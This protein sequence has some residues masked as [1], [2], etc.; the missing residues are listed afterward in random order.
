[1]KY[2]FTYDV[3]TLPNCCGVF[4]VG[5][6]EL[7]TVYEDTIKRYKNSYE[8]YVDDEKT[9]YQ[10]AFVRLLAGD[11]DRPIQFWFVRYKD[12]DTEEF[13]DEYH[14]DT[15]RRMVQDHKGVIHLGTYINPNTGNEID[16]YLINSG[17]TKA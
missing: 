14:H 9:A 12:E 13:D 3:N 2:K 17:A 7:H 4:E 11:G 16:G 1:M 15:F 10:N 8:G 6:F 5:D